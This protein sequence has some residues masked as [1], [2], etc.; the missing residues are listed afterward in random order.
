MSVPANTVGHVAEAFYSPFSSRYTHIRYI[1]VLSYTR[2][3]TFHY[4]PQN[5]CANTE[6][7]PPAPN[8]SG[9]VEHEHTDFANQ[10]RD[11][12]HE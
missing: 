6:V 1:P 7:M 4:S 2:P 11:V 5:M 8:A 9:H 12:F 3:R 10:A